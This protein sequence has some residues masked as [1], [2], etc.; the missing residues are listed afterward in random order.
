[1]K[2]IARRLPF[3]VPEILQIGPN[4]AWTIERRLPGRSMA[5]LL[6]ELE[7]AQRETAFR[8]YVAAIDAFR[9]V[10]LLYIPY[11]HV[12][13]T[14]PV[15]ATDWRTF[16]RRSLA[17]FAARNRAT[18][19]SEIGNPDALVAKAGAMVTAMPEHPP[20]VL[21]HGDYFPGNVMLDDDLDVSAVLDFGV[22]TVAGDPQLDLGVGYL[23]LELIDECGPDD[24]PFVRDLI[25]ARHSKA[26]EP[27]LR[28]YRA[29]LAFSMA[30]PANAA[31]PYPRLY[32]WSLAQLRLLAE[33][34]LPA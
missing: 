14:A 11:G 17:G 25:V 5:S 32:D 34:R 15:R 10:S 18:I 31:P 28:F 3:A 7:G 4:E 24:A 8:N 1:L 20:K 30:D 6:R 13:G 22:F 27:A 29:Y 9:S 2:S 19:T 21:V 26:I 33:D 12:L 16:L 23:T